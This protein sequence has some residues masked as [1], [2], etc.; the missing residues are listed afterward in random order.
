MILAAGRG[1]RMR[2]LSDATP[3]PLLKVRGKPLMQWPLEALARGGFGRVVVN[4]AWLGEQI[5]A[6]FGS[7]FV[8]Q[9]ASNKRNRLLNQEQMQGRLRIAYSHEGRDFGGALETAGGVA[10]ALPL[11]CPLETAGTTSGVF[12]VLAGDVF[13]PDFAFSQAAVERFVASGR[14]AHLWLVPNPAHH[15]RGDFGLSP[16][17]L[18]LNPP[19]GDPRQRYTYSTIG[20]YHKALFAPPWCD[21]PAGN[22]GGLRAP[23]APLLRAAIDDQRVSAELY[24]GAWTDVGTPERLVELNQAVMR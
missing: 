11:L 15:P 21:I 8:L 19:S 22:P 14:L 24:E 9:P 7:V 10:R 6:K 20:L 2:P 17:G 23:L 18:A 5:S 12:W 4:T 13:A 3:K 1:E 16:E